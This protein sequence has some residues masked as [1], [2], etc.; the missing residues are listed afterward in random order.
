MKTLKFYGASDDLFELKCSDRALANEICNDGDGTVMGFHLKADD[1]ELRVCAYYV[2][3]GVWMI[4][5]APVEEGQP[6][7]SWAIRLESPGASNE[8]PEYSAVIV[9]DAPDDVIVTVVA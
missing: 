2:D 5:V 9:V 1:G 8:A 4:G 7:P 3:P 6:I